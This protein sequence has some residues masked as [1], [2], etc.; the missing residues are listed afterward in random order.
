MVFF[1]FTLII[2]CHY[3][4]PVKSPGKGSCRM[5]YGGHWHLESGTREFPALSREASVR[6]RPTS[7]AV[8]RICIYTIKSDNGILR[9]SYPALLHGAVTSNLQHAVRTSPWSNSYTRPPKPGRPSALVA[10]LPSSDHPPGT[11]RGYHITASQPGVIV[12]RQPAASLRKASCW[13]HAGEMSA[14]DVIGRL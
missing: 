2:Q 12:Y 13:G 9:F 5:L 7:G 1:F 11:T 4:A 14:G 10:C 3:Y 8:A 6:P